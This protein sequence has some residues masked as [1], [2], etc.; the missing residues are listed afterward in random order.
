MSIF[1]MPGLRSPRSLNRRATIMAV[2]GVAAMGAG[3]AYVAT[4]AV[5]AFPENIVV[6][7]D[8]DFVTVEGY[9]DHIGATALVEVTRPGVGVV[10]SAK[11]VVEAGDVAFEINHPG[12]YCWGNDTGLNVT[13]DI[14]AGDKVSIK[15]DGV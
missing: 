11:G 14:R 3:G 6:F 13:P 5:P 7:P 15:F 4:A 8:R 12:G 1:S 2:A 10:G 9:Q